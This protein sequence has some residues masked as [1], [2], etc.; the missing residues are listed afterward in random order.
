MVINW[1]SQVHDIIN[2][3]SECTPCNTRS[4]GGSPRLVAVS[5]PVQEVN[6]WI[7][8]QH[9]F[10]NLYKQLSCNTHKSVGYILEEIDSPYYKPFTKMLKNVVCAWHEAQ[11]VSLWLHPLLRQ[12]SAF[13]A[14]SFANAQELILPL[15]HVI[16]LLWSNARHY[17]TTARMTVMLR[18]ICNLMIRRASED[19]ELATLFQSDADE[20][21]LKITKTVGILEMFKSKLLEYKSK[22]TSNQPI[23]LPALSVVPPP[24]GEMYL[25]SLSMASGAAE[26]QQLWRFSNE[27]VFGHALY[28]FLEQ[29]AEIQKVFEA[30]VSFQSLEKME[31]GGCIGKH[32]T[33]RIRQIH[34]DFK[35]LFEE[36]TKLDIDLSHSTTATSTTTAA[37]KKNP[38]WQ[39]FRREQAIFF[40]HM[41][42]LEKKLATILLQAFGDCHNWEQLTKLTTMFANILQ[43]QSIQYEL[44]IILPHI[45]A[46]YDD[47][48]LP[49]EGIVGNVLLAFEYRGVAAIPLERS[50]FPPM[51]AA[52]MWLE[53]CMRRCDVFA[54]NE[55][56]ALIKVWLVEGNPLSLQ[57]EK[58]TARRNILTTKLSNLQLKVWHNWQQTIE[59]RIAQGLDSK[60][61][62][63]HHNAGSDKLIGQCHHNGKQDTEGGRVGVDSSGCSQ[64]YSLS[65]NSND[66]IVQSSTKHYP[67]C[68]P[69]SS[70]WP[71]LNYTHRCRI[72]TNTA[73]TA[74]SESKAATAVAASPSPSSSSTGTDTTSNKILEMH[75]SI[76]LFTLLR[77]TKYLL[78]LQE[79]YNKRQTLL[80]TMTTALCPT[81]TPTP[82]PPTQPQQAEVVRQHNQ[83]QQSPQPQPQQLLPQTL[84][85]LYAQRDIFWHRKIRLMQ[86]AEYYN[87]IREPGGL[88]TA[89][90]EMQLIQ[91]S[92]SVIDEHLDL[93]A[94]SLTWRNYDSQLIDEI[95]HKAKNLYHHLAEARANVQ[96]IMDSINRWSREPL[97]QRSIYGK[98]LLELR[99]QE[100]RLRTRL[101]QCEDTK[102]LLN[103]LLAKNFCLFFNYNDEGGT[104]QNIQEFLQ[105]FPQDQQE[106]FEPY[107][108]SI[109]RLI[110]HEVR[111]SMRISLEY[112]LNEM[113]TT[114]TVE[115]FKP[116]TTTTAAST[117]A[118]MEAKESC[119]VNQASRSLKSIQ[120]P[121]L[122]RAGT[123]ATST[124]NAATAT[125]AKETA[126]AAAGGTLT[127]LKTELTG[128]K[129]TTT[130]QTLPTTTTTS[131]H[132]LPHLLKAIQGRHQTMEQQHQHQ[133][134]SQHLPLSLDGIPTVTHYQHWQRSPMRLT[135]L[136]ETSTPAHQHPTATMVATKSSPL[137]EVKL[138]LHHDS[139][140]NFEPSFEASEA[141]NFQQIV[142]QLLDDI[143]KACKCM[144][145]VFQDDTPPPRSS[146]SPPTLQPLTCSNEYAR[147]HQPLRSYAK[148]SNV[149]QDT[150]TTTTTATTARISSAT[151]TAKDKV[152]NATNVA[153]IT[154]TESSLDMC[155]VFQAEVFVVM[156][157]LKT[158]SM[159]ERPPAKTVPIYVGSL[160]AL[161]ALT[162]GHIMSKLG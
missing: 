87:S 22:Y 76:E 118:P 146:P 51:A 113:A 106:K 116:P 3:K 63:L 125:M 143:E 77:E 54:A 38:N 159:H 140:I 91:P 42:V 37:Q 45:L 110:Y 124:T 96:R 10:E 71:V 100:Q 120:T 61:M 75:F 109:D 137:F 41:E 52:I 18:C 8:R 142:E 9:N 107:L 60:L 131:K 90:T 101:L 72:V 16:H 21:L 153:T 129:A 62:T 73:T 117:L 23:L 49:I 134:Q 160:A 28:G 135:P 31:I 14:V 55:L 85:D 154:Q 103:Q 88:L 95:Y 144:P 80:M 114:A 12:T 145:R 128:S 15:V 66:G 20:G 7:N 44:R 112:L 65:R 82:T 11:E 25:D 70:T 86:I 19:L 43:R 136:T 26:V 133:Q 27:D 127:P 152:M 56:N 4:K 30:A 121:T 97:H 33:E 147:I 50:N 57:Y 6:F 119:R 67:S 53:N 132:F 126:A 74:M 35:M 36:W 102:L 139:R 47:E 58:L 40:Q 89:S 2:E 115:T 148:Y 69:A 13:N 93:A 157:A 138:Q 68:I 48:L 99:H 32:L 108:L 81:Q 105:K 104:N 98:N 156:K 92:V 34:A 59:K 29:L 5:M 162:S 155:N 158:I 123:K 79:L 46:V 122:T 24:N 149:R 84:L 78:A 130:A 1:S 141:T 161:K 83:Q 64:R 94:T 111:Q 17:R 151:T 150:I 39:M